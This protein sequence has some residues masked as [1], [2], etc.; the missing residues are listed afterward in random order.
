MPSDPFRVGR[1]K[2][3]Q[4]AREHPTDI[5]LPTQPNSAQLK[6]IPYKEWR[7]HKYVLY[8]DQHGQGGAPC[9]TPQRFSTASVP[10]QGAPWKR[11]AHVGAQPLPRQL[12]LV[13]F[14]AAG[15]T[16]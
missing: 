2:V 15:L 6:S 10:P 11:P 16:L 8:V 5:Y 9:C 13:A 7:K 3:R 12:E 1:A 4:L 14:K